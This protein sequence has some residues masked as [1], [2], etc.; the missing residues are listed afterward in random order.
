MK[1]TLEKIEN[2][3]LDL[4]NDAESANEHGLSTLYRSLAEILVGNLDDVSAY[5]VMKAV[6]ERGGFLP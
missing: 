2:I 3:V 4:E 6:Q 5:K 1:T